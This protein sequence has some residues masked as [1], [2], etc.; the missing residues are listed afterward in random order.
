MTK[1]EIL[2]KIRRMTADNGG[3]APGSM[4]FATAT[5][6][7]RSDWYPKLWLRWGDATREAI[8]QS[9]ALAAAYEPAYLITKYIELIRNLG[10]FPIDGEL[11]LKR[12]VDKS[13]PSRSTFDRLGT[14][15]DRAAKIL[16]FCRQQGGLD[17]VLKVCQDVLGTTSID[18]RTTEPGSRTVGYVY[19]IKHGSRRQYKIGKTDNPLRREGEVRLQLPER[20]AP[21]H[22]IETDDMSGVE[23]YWHNRFKSKRLEGKWFALE[24]ADVAAF[25]RWKKIW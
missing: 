14:K 3:I 8:G 17:D 20:A 10:R 18:P 1:E 19:M 7:R 21:L 4:A 24:A 23:A 9:N 11:S 15:L 16:E 22:F 5:G 25:K 13:F 6:L 2:N 12:K